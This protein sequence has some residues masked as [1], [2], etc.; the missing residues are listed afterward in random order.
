MKY[1]TTFFL[2]CLI[3]QNVLTSKTLKN[4]LI[5]LT[6]EMK[7]HSD[8]KESKSSQLQKI[9]SYSEG[10]DDYVPAPIE[11]YEDSDPT[12]NEF[13][14]AT[15]KDAQVEA[16]KPV[17]SNGYTIESKDAEIQIIKFHSF[18][19]EVGE[20]K[21]GLG[22]SFYFLGGTIPFSVIYRL[23]ITYNSRLRNLQ[24]TQAESVRADC[25][26][27]D[28]ALDG[29]NV[30]EGEVVDYF[31]TANATQDASNAQIQLNTDVELALANKSGSYETKSFSTINFVGNAVEESK[32]IQNY[33]NELISE[34]IKN[35]IISMNKNDLIFEGEYSTAEERRRLT[36]VT[37][38]EIKPIIMDINTGGGNIHQYNCTSN[39]YSTTNKL[40][41]ICDTSSHP[42]DTFT[43]NLH[44]S[45]G[46]IDEIS[47]VELFEVK[48][49]YG[50]STAIKTGGSSESISYNYEEVAPEEYTETEED[51]AETGNANA[52]DAQVDA[53]KPISTKGYTTDSKDSD[54]QIMKFHSYSTSVE[55]GKI[56]FNTIFYFHNKT[57]PHTTVYR[58]RIT[59]N[60]ESG[61]RNLQTVQAD[62]ARTDCVITDP[63]LSGTIQTE[64][65]AVDYGCSAFASHDATNANVAI[66]SDFNLVLGDRD[67]NAETYDF[68]EISF[69]STSSE[70]ATGIESNSDSYSGLDTL[71][72]STVSI[73]NYDLIFTGTLESANALRRLSLEDGD[74]ISMDLLTYKN[75]TSSYKQYNCTLNGV[76]SPTYRLTCDTS[77]NPINTSVAN[78]HLSTGKSDDGTMLTIEM[79]DWSNNSTQIK[80]IES[81]DSYEEIASEEYTATAVNQAETGNATAKDAQVNASKPVSTNGY[82]E[83]KKESNVQIMKFHSYDSSEE[84]KVKFNSFFYFAGRRIPHRTIF[85]LRIT[86]NSVSGLRNLQTVEA[87]SS[88]TDCFI[89][90]TSKEG[91]ISSEGEV[92]DYNCS[93]NTAQDVSNAEVALNT[94]FD[95][96]L[97]ERNGS[98]ESYDFDEVSF[99]GNSS[100]EARSIQSYSETYNGETDTLTNVIATIEDY[101]LILTGELASSSSNLRRL[102]LKKGDVIEMNL[103]TKVNGTDK[104]YKYNC[105][106][107]EVSSPTFRLT[108]DTSKNPI[109][110]N[111]EN[112][113]LSTGRS[114][115]GTLLS[116]KLKDWKGNTTSITPVGG[117][118]GNQTEV[119]KKY[120]YSKSSSGL[121]GGAIAGI[122]IACVATVAALALAV[123]LLKKPSVPQNSPIHSVNN[124]TEVHI[125][126]GNA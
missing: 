43:E 77:S 10:G 111:A 83:D 54:V 57:I 26:L 9:A 86:Y 87:Y 3:I 98:Y 118:G 58:V 40:E 63:S 12:S 78:L 69:T 88:R 114:G 93:A 65:V 38:G 37:E 13:T 101:I 23:R 11:E 27:T 112:L 20:G 119:N 122:V 113:H 30:T 52:A 95:L 32:N 16:T 75:G 48:D 41:V 84:G 49:G 73:N 109:D 39:R 123:F 60:S 81:S 62:S 6:N 105:T 28:S 125:K 47:L 29:K 67:G 68:N 36:S 76:S 24:T 35:T 4:P 100:E 59:Y 74:K 107:N 14:T 110:T 99:T 17:S 15:A 117:T 116:L 121:S 45:T 33:K 44:L 106:L 108:C 102:S 120:S 56:N 53:S 89:F 55:E 85:R 90:D 103:K 115:D 1:K 94:D 61:L 97:A 7:K 18:Q 31:C 70:E 2:F 64:G 71:K 50:N 19:P 124:S 91:N 25:L 21:I 8:T 46:V 42:I 79:K 96:I 66:N 22:T 82:T 5:K 80:T 72:N 51:Q 126:P 104:I 92:V 34:L